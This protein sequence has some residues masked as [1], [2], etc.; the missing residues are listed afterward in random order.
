MRS[1]L[2]LISMTAVTSIGFDIDLIKSIGKS[3]GYDNVSI[4]VYC[5]LMVLSQLLM[6]GNIDLIISGFTISP[7][8]A[9]KVDFSDP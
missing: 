4:S 1:L 7:E 8:R 9:K 6:T 3:L 2:S 5:H